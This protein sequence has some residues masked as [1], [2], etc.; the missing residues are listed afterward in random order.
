[1]LLVFPFQ[2]LHGEGR[3]A[4]GSTVVVL[5]ETAE[6][7]AVRARMEEKYLPYPQQGQ[8]QRGVLLQEPGLFQSS[9][10]LGTTEYI[11]MKNKYSFASCHFAIACVSQLLFA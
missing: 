9:S 11:S 1:M 6:R 10:D 7:A 8:G 4:D 5:G 2:V 3:W